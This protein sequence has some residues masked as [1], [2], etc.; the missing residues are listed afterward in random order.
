MNDSNHCFKRFDLYYLLFIVSF[1]FL[2]II[3]CTTPLMGEDYAL[4]TTF[5]SSY[6]LKGTVELIEAILWR[7]YAQMTGWNVRIGEQISIAFG[8]FDKMIFN[9]C[10]SAIA[11]YFIWLISAYVYKDSWKRNEN[12]AWKFLISFSMIMI[13]QPS[14]GEIFFWRTGSTNYLWAICILLTFGLPIRYFVGVNSI[15]LIGNSYIKSSFLSIL[16]FFAGF[17]NENT[18]IAFMALYIGVIIWGLVKKIRIP[19]WIY[20][21]FVTFAAG[22]VFMCKAPSTVHRIAFYNE[23]FNVGKVGLNGY[24]YRAVNVLNTFFVTHKFYVIIL[25]CCIFL[26]GGG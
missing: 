18:P 1:A 16:G 21:S 10:N 22:F 5:A 19:N 6:S 17:T 23:I 3:N 24:L 20:V 15:D 7:I 13:F 25:M 26:G 8:F 4:T 2:L 9:I 11:L 14:L 12:R